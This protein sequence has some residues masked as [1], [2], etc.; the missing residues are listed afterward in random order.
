MTR[1]KLTLKNII[2]DGPE[3]KKKTLVVKGSK[4][5][6]FYVIFYKKSFLFVELRSAKKTKKFSNSKTF[7]IYI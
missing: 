6:L 3:I 1:P 2:F 5:H 4:L 7:F